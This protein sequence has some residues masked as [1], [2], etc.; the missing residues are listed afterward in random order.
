M[1]PRA[2]GSQPSATVPEHGPGCPGKGVIP[3]QQLGCPPLGQSYARAVPSVLS[4]FGAWDAFLA[5]QKEGLSLLAGCVPGHKQ[6]GLW[7]G[8]SLPGGCAGDGVLAVP[9]LPPCCWQG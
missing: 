7:P 3:F 4:R 1:L 8:R 2:P 6:P 5:C 9:G